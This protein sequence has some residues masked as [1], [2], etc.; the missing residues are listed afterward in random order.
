MIYLDSRYA[1]GPLVKANDARNESYQ[2]TVF[3]KFPGYFVEFY[4][5][6]WK[7]TDRWDV[8]ATNSLGKPDLW[9][10]ILDINPEII[11]PFDVKPGTMLRVPRA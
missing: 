5:Y 1:D 2:V 3:R 8:L 6:T 10:Q 7:E 4:W 11:D 9:W